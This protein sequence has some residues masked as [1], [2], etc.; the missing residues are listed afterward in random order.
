MKRLTP[1]QM[2]RR[3]LTEDETLFL[4]SEIA[5][6]TVTAGPDG[7]PAQPT[8]KERITA[9]E[10]IGR[11]FSLFEAQSADGRGVVIL[12]DDVKK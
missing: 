11:R 7:S 1:R 5:R 10:L 6:G 8:V 3:C 9:L 4:L 12:R 2:A